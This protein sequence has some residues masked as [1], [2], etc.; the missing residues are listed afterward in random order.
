MTTSFF[1]THYQQGITILTFKQIE[2][3]RHL[4]NQI[5]TYIIVREYY[6]NK[7]HVYDI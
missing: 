3:I 1:K 2:E 4:K 7:N 5:L 6:I